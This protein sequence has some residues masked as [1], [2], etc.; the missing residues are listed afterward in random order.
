MRLGMDAEELK[1]ELREDEGDPQQK[2]MRKRMYQEFISQSIVNGVRQAA[3]LVLGRSS[4][5]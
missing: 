5:N 3:L 1:R 2:G 4:R